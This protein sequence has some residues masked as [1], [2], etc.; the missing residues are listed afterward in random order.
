MLGVRLLLTRREEVVLKRPT[1]APAPTLKGVESRPRRPTPK[2]TLPQLVAATYLMVAGGPYGLEEIV[3]RAGFTGAIVILLVTPL[4]WSVPTALLVGE[5]S[6]ALPESG[7]Y[8]AWVRRAMGP[9]WGFQEAWLSLVASIFDMAIYPTLFSLYLARLF[10]ALGEGNAPTIVGALVLAFCTAVNLQGARAVGVSS[11]LF[12]LALLTPFAFVIVGASIRPAVPAND[13]NAG[14]LD[15]V[16]GILVAMWNYMG[17]DNSST[18]ASE[19]EQPERTYPM[20]MMIVLA[21]VA[22]TYVLP[23]LAVSH[24]G[25]ARSEWSTGSWASVADLV[26]GPWLKIAMIVGGMFSALGMLNAL[27]MSYSRIPAVLA[28]DGYLPAILARRNLA[29][30]APT[31]SILVCAVG[32]GL[33]LNLG[34]QRLVEID[35][36]L[37]GLSLVLEFVALLVLRIREP[38]LARPYRVP[39]GIVVAALLGVA[40]TSLIVLALVRNSNERI[41][42]L[43]ALVFGLILVAAGFLIFAGSRLLRK[44]TARCNA[45]TTQVGEKKVEQWPECRDTP[46]V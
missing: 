7:G 14:G 42:R 36:L 38:G 37:Y 15:L 18:L 16:G 39:G 1:E 8:Y 32:W 23:I 17:W 44:S 11:V 19:V 27:I 20:A 31:V 33:A 25:I 46:T 10:P 2:I 35:L 29:T 12:S 9:F 43:N 5:L 40:P 28:E 3:G 41:G 22:F 26:A 30:G 24:V 34:F 45:T 4:L 21:L 6:S 13:T